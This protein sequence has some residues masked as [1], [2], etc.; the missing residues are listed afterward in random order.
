MNADFSTFK[1]DLTKK[2][3][4]KGEYLYVALTVNRNQPSHTSIQ[5]FDNPTPFF[6]N[7]FMSPAYVVQVQDEILSESIVNRLSGVNTR[8]P[9]SRTAL[10]QDV[11]VILG[12]EPHSFIDFNI[13]M[14]NPHAEEYVIR[15]ED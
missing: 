6:G 15:L 10:L 14:K 3:P 9:N 7:S 5:K 13:V 11:C 2:V 1:L 8:G 4:P 12:L